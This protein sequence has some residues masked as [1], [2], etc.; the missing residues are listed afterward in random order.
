MACRRRAK[1]LACEEKRRV[2]EQLGECTLWKRHQRWWSV[3][4]LCLGLCGWAA[5]L[6]ND[7]PPKETLE[8]QKQ[9]IIGGQP[10]LRY[11][12]VGALTSNRSSFCTGTL[13]A[14]RVVLTAAHCVDAALE[15]KGAS[16]EFRID[17][18]DP[19]ASSG[20]QANYF[21]FD[22]ALFKN[23]PI[24]NTNLSNGGDIGFGILKQAV[25]I[26]QPIAVNVNTDTNLWAS[27]SP[28]FLGYGLL[29]S[30][31]TRI[32]ADRKHGVEIPIVQVLADRFTHQATGKSVCHGDSGGPALVLLDGKV[33]VIGVNSYVSAP[34]VQGANP[35]RSSCT[36]SGTSMRTD[37][38][39]TFIQSILS[40]YGDGPEP[41]T[42]DA[43]CGVCRRC[44]SN[45]F[46]EGVP[47]NQSAGICGACKSDKDCAGGGCFR[48]QD[49]YRCLVA[50]DASDCCPDGQ[51][52]AT[53]QTQSGVTKLCM[54]FEGA[55]PPLA[56]AN[57]AACGAGEFCENG[58]C[59]P[60]PVARS[61][62]LCRSCQS[63]ADCQ[64]SGGYCLGIAGHRYCSQP[65][66][67]GDFCPAGYVCQEPY[68]G[69][70]RQCLPEDGACQL[71][72]LFDTHCAKGQ[73]CTGGVCAEPQGGGFAAS[74][75]PV[76]C[77]DPLV[78]KRTLSGKRCLPACGAPAG[79]AGSACRDGTSCD[80]PM[81]CYTLASSQNLCLHPCNSD[82]DCGKVGGGFCYQSV[83]ACRQSSDCGQ[84]FSCNASSG[85]IGACVADQAV[86]SC[87]APYVCESFQGES[88]CVSPTPGQRALGQ[89]C[90]PLNRCKEGLACIRT[91]DGSFCVEDCSQSKTCQLGGYCGKPNTQIDICYCAED[92]DCGADR[93]CRRVFRPFGICEGKLA[94]NPCRNDGEC[95]PTYACRGGRC[96]SGTELE[97]WKD[98]TTAADAGNESI[99]ESI[100][101]PPAESAAET[102]PE[103]QP[104]PTAET[105]PENTVEII[106]EPPPK[107]GC[108]CDASSDASPSSPP[109]FGIFAFFLLFFFRRHRSPSSPAMHTAP[110]DLL[111]ERDHPKAQTAS[112]APPKVRFV[113]WGVW[114]GG[115]AL[116]PSF[117]CPEPSVTCRQDADCTQGQT[118]QASRCQPPQETTPERSAEATPEIPLDASPEPSVEIAPEA[119][120]ETTPEIAP[121]ASS[122]PSVEITPE[123]G[124]EPQP[125]ALPEEITHLP[126]GQRPNACAHTNAPT[127][128]LPSVLQRRWE[129]YTENNSR[130]GILRMAVSPDGKYLASVDDEG[131]IVRVW[132]LATEQ[133]KYTFVEATNALQSVSWS[134]DSQTLAAVGSDRLV[135]LWKVSD[136]TYRSGL[137]K[138]TSTLYTAV[139]SPDGQWIASGGADR[140]I[141]LWKVSDRSLALEL[142]GHTNTVWALAF[143]PDSKTLYSA[144]SD[145]EIRYWDVATGQS[146][147]QYKHHTGAIRGMAISPDGK[148]LATVSLS[149]D[150]T[151][152]LIEAATGTV[153]RSW[154]GHG[155]SSVYDVAFHP[156][157][158]RFATVATDRYVRVWATQNAQMLY[159]YRSSQ[160]PY[161]VGWL[162]DGKRLVIASSDQHLEFLNDA[163]GQVLQ[164]IHAH[165]DRVS[166][167]ATS[168]DGAWVALANARLNDIQIW[169]W[170]KPV[171][172]RTLQG[173][174]R[175]VRALAISADGRFLASASTDRSVR[176]WNLQDGTFLRS[177]G[178][179]NMVASSVALSKDGETAFTAAWDGLIRVWKTSDGTLIRTLQGHTREIT[180]LSLSEDNSLLLSASVDQSARL[181][182]LSDGTLQRTI[183]TTTPLYAVALHPDLSVLATGGWNGQIQIWKTSDG[184]LQRS[185]DAHSGNI[186]SLR[187]DPQGQT[188]VSAS[189]DRSVRVWRHI[190]GVLLQ[191]LRPR[192]QYTT[193]LAF[194]P[195][196]NALVTA[197]SDG[198]ADIWSFQP[199]PTPTTLDLQSGSLLAI[200][201]S[202]DQRLAATAT[203]DN[204]VRLWDR[205][206]NTLL[207]TLSDA[208]EPINAIAL[209]PD[210]RFLAAASASRV[211]LWQTSDGRLLR[212]FLGQRDQV[213][214]LSFRPDS[215]VLAVA[216]WDGSVRLWDWRSGLNQRTLL[217]DNSRALSIAWSL[218][219]ERLVAGL[220]NQKILVWE[221]TTGKRLRALEGHTGGVTHLLF[222]RDGLR[223]YS[224]SYDA[225]VRIWDPETGAL[226]TTLQGHTKTVQQIAL[227]RDALRLVSA[228]HDGTLRLW[229]LSNNTTTQ[230]L[231]LGQDALYSV[232]LGQ[233]AT[234]LLAGGSDGI[235]RTWNLLRDPRLQILERYPLGVR[236]LAF[237]NDGSYLAS[238][239]ALRLGR[240]D[241]RSDWRWLHTLS[242]HSTDLRALAIS[243]DSRLI[244]TVGADKRVRVATLADNQQRFSDN[245]QHTAPIH[246][247]AF[248]PD[249]TQLATAG[250]D[251]TIL[252]WSLS[253]NQVSN[254]LLGHTAAITD[255]AYHPKGDWLVSAS[256]DNT[257]RLWNPQTAA[258]LH[259]LQGHTQGIVSLSIHPQTTQIASA[260]LDGSVRLWDA[261]TTM[262]LQTLTTT[263]VPTRLRFSTQ[264]HWLAIAYNDGRVDLRETKTYTLS[265]TLHLQSLPTQGLAWAPDDRSLALGDQTA[266][267]TLFSCEQ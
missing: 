121:D 90:D 10:D 53:L 247:A 233:E 176:L 231:H 9:P 116:L 205:S 224:A 243:P 248:L 164:R 61:A 204:K 71:P 34:S 25:N 4:F 23:H 126:P 150:R 217:T 222:S 62:G 146:T 82:T 220:F 97:Q 179:H 198:N 103:P 2:A 192:N 238:G 201:L 73:T 58:V 117:G 169:A 177:L 216:S 210:Q 42:Q 21:A 264:G 203:A 245:Q 60:Q 93:V 59:Q 254:K 252:L 31:P 197:G 17:L 249:N 225:T 119:P 76:P 78:C 36:G 166:S 63:Q 200:A 228:S 229:D 39:T 102:T 7:A 136:G 80:A 52:C 133:L 159:E 130:F 26:A 16:V 56:C 64:D 151:T 195:Q 70:P 38:Y 111:K 183:Q 184:S 163:N 253:N 215:N 187:F 251:N 157:G 115:L 206:Q 74:C 241:R 260:S 234:L 118:C 199:A 147:Q 148:T 142:N 28:L 3:V 19:N 244:A 92:K 86:Q 211:Y 11:P 101:E 218:N 154:Q 91:N 158:T 152:K 131:R 232:A 212:S 189:Y 266:W 227:S 29:Q 72:C 134:P 246:A 114:I 69:L 258:L 196:H 267:I 75:D 105:A 77:Q 88:Y 137:S 109:Y 132:D 6:P 180:S 259:T 256:L 235:L 1:G 112:N 68:A 155:S 120:N 83:C 186:R 47:I 143:S 129:A 89:S 168:P 27:K 125:E 40:S 255:L 265:H 8:H 99:A 190:D 257:L 46:C 202:N 250:D 98:E 226:R 113:V 35:P 32:S 22:M 214:A 54:P 33:R 161:S 230:T 207:H 263:G 144:S 106:A 135:H 239:S 173:H 24:W 81:S 178:P 193:S 48:F 182:K 170:Q 240:I 87:T 160:S 104:E 191:T 94:S 123:A 223:L 141:R 66:G 237:S 37:T 44:A 43:D 55:C 50:C 165:F 209:S 5:C 85:V 84:G 139:F 145:Q 194:L 174:T 110:Q 67:A 162:P 171:L 261:Q 156:D 15:N 185:L 213:S 127:C 122:E 49:G 107:A 149:P 51:Y 79:K 140:I 208:T 153:L 95:P 221:A 175:G 167:V 242:N 128:C 65:C 30:T 138:H 100:P 108:G 12:A 124:P 172:V 188:L 45:Q 57:T 181:W 13:I 262:T 96:L 236:T 219:G 18:P 20:F 41:C 14:K